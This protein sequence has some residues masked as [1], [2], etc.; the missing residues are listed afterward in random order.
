M[1]Q[2][3]L[4]KKSAKAT[5]SGRGGPVAT[6]RRSRQGPQRQRRDGHAAGPASD[7]ARGPERSAAERPSATE[8]RRGSEELAHIL[9]GADGDLDRLV[10]II[11]EH[12]RPAAARA[13][14]VRPDV[15]PL[16]NGEFPHIAL[17]LADL[18]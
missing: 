12:G 17:S 16:I 15:V 7:I 8:R 10:T 4:D 13:A 18:D 1:N 6:P 11:K 14:S 3:L 9:A 2:Q 5:G